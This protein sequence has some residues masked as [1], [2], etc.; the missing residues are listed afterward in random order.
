MK[1]KKDIIKKKNLSMEEKEK[2]NIIEKELSQACEDREWEKLENVLGSL[3]TNSGGTDN[4]NVWRELR[5]AFTK[6]VK[7]VPTGFKNIEGKT[8]T[9]SKEKKKVI[10]KHFVHRMRKRQ[11]VE[12]VK[13]ILN[14]KKETFALKLEMAKNNK[15]PPIQM[16]E[17]EKVLK[18]LK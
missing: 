6:K 3:E 1:E 18:S 14:T 13:D 16:E 12:E 11:A 4:L 10:L 15:S 2:V 17:L 9:N 5:K 8:V 7:S